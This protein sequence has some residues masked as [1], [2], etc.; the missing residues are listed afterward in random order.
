MY[1]CT[2]F[3]MYTTPWN[4][5]LLCIYSFQVSHVAKVYFHVWRSVLLSNNMTLNQCSDIE[6]FGADANY[7]ILKV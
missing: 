3:Y 4:C 7:Y 2:R 6:V 5:W 1:V